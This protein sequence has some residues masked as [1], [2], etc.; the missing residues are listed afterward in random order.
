MRR[1][2]DA[3]VVRASSEAKVAAAETVSV[4]GEG[5]GADEERPYEEYEVKGRDGDTCV[6]VILPGQFEVEEAQ[7]T[8]TGWGW[9]VE[10]ARHSSENFTSLARQLYFSA[11]N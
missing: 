4:G 9:R 10:R 3:V 6:E 5:E 11:C 2:L 8:A 1:A 7:S